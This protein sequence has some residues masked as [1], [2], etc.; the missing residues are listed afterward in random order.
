MDS[1]WMG[2]PVVNLPGSTAIARGGKSI[3][4]NIG[5]PELIADSEEHYVAIA[6]DLAADIPRLAE[7]RRGLRTRM[8]TSPLMDATR[9]ARDF[10]NALRQMWE[11]WCLTQLG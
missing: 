6:D 8:E 3:L 7:L 9:F 11:T 2:V 4:T 1:L 5:L 10:E